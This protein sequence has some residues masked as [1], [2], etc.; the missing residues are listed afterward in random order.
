M[1]RAFFDHTGDVGVS[2]HARSLPELFREAA[3]AL[4]E[5]MTE[6]VHVRRE[7]P[8]R[9]EIAAAGLDDLLVDWLGELLYRFEVQNLLVARADVDVGQTPTGWSLVATAW[10]EPFDRARHPI[11]VLIKGITYHRLSI[12][13]GDDHWY[14]DV[15]FDI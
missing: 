15:V 6:L 12:T 5:T 1:P 7:S 10:G 14:T 3:M 2:L 11:K 4:T 8:H 13:Q 9:I